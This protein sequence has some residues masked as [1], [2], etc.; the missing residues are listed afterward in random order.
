MK[1]VLKLDEIEIRI[2]DLDRKIT[3]LKEER[4][5]RLKERTSTRRRMAVDR[6]IVCGGIVLDLAAKEEAFRR[7]LTNILNRHL[8]DP[9]ARRLF[10]DLLSNTANDNV[11]DQVEEPMPSTGES[12][13]G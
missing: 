4:D 3:Q 8:D 2:A 1:T 13:H 6:K 11:Q 9:I 7:V 5:R 10:S 12:S